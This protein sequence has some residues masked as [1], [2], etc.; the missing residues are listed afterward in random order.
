MLRNLI[1][2]LSITMNLCKASSLIFCNA[3]KSISAFTL[4]SVSGLRNRIIPQL[5]L[6]SLKVNSPKSLSDVIMSRLFT[7]AYSII[8]E[9]F[10]PFINSL[11]ARI[12]TL[13]SLKMEIIG[14]SIFSSAK[15]LIRMPMVWLHHSLSLKLHKPGMQKGHP[16]S[17]QDSFELFPENSDRRTF[18]QGQ[19]LQIS[20][21]PLSQV[22]H[23]EYLDWFR[24]CHSS[25]SSQL[26]YFLQ[27]YGKRVVSQKGLYGYL[28]R[29]KVRF[30]SAI[31]IS[32]IVTN[33]SGVSLFFAWHYQRLGTIAEAST[34]NE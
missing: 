11:T 31:S 27:K 24:Y 6:Y 1:L 21:Y 2:N 15:N 25:F 14:Y 12:S 23:K 5:G 20:G 28:S 33:F 13:F 26:F 34:L 22:C 3:A 8:S 18:S 29:A 4:Q 9:S 10:A 19:V 17:S 7:K 16:L 32:K 30:I